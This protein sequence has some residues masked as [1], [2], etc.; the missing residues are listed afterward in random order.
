MK[1]NSPI[2]RSLVLFLVLALVQCGFSPAW[3]RPVE[4]PD[5]LPDTVV[6]GPDLV[7]FWMPPGSSA[8][9]DLYT[10][11]SAR[12][13]ATYSKPSVPITVKAASG[14]TTRLAVDV[15]AADRA[16]EGW[17]WYGKAAV[18]VGSVA[19][20]GLATWAIVEASHNGSHDN[21]SSTHYTIMGGDEGSTVNVRIDSPDTS[22][23]SGW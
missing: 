1:T 7:S 10:L 2:F 15:A 12:Y 8:G 13:D 11:A 17:P 22:T 18:V 23:R 20:V 14:E 9:P 5:V 4:V 19:L 21:D 16:T 3:A 6:G